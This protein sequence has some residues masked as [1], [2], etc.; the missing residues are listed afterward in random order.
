MSQQN[1]RPSLKRHIA[2]TN[3]SSARAFGQFIA[4]TPILLRRNP[5]AAVHGGTM[6]RN[7]EMVADSLA[8]LEKRLWQAVIVTTIQE[9]IS[10]PLRS[11]R[12]AEEYLF[13]DQKD[14]PLVCQSAGMD[15]DRLRA[16]LNRL[17]I[18]NPALGFDPF[19]HPATIR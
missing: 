2:L 15:A 13:Q 4:L 19:A 6:A 8:A 16:K 1:V 14:F 7:A 10:G 18:Q 12:R 9:W 17:R 3:K 5:A 11:K